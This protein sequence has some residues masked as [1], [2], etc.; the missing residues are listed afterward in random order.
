MTIEAVFCGVSHS[1]AV[2]SAGVCYA[3]GKN[4]SGQCGETDPQGSD[5]VSVSLEYCSDILCL[6]GTSCFWIPTPVMWW[7]SR[8]V[9]VLVLCFLFGAFPLVGFLKH[10]PSRVAYNAATVRKGQPTTMISLFET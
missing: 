2:C 9:Y 5:A 8:L 4:G 10:P 1:L 6:C 7:D 3:W